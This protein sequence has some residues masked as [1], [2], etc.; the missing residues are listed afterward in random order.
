VIYA[1]QQAQQRKLRRE[2]LEVEWEA[3][4]GEE[5]AEL[6]SVSRVLLCL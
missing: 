2:T 3:V 4:N 6:F 1:S 5:E